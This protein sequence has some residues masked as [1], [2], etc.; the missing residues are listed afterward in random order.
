MAMQLI[1]RYSFTGATFTQATDCQSYP[2]TKH[3]LVPHG[4]CSTVTVKSES[5]ASLIKYQIYGVS[6]L[7]TQN[8][9]NNK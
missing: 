2:A 7:P 1:L 9:K 4:S 3:V 6:G 5:R 8:T